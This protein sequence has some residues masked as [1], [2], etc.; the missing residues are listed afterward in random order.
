[1]TTAPRD[2]MVGCPFCGVKPH[3]PCKVR[4]PKWLKNQ[5]S[6]PS[7]MERHLAAIELEA[8]ES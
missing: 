8:T 4:L 6:T 3:Q 5:Q 1:M 2:H 7:H